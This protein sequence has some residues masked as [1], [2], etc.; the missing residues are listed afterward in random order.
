MI[1]SSPLQP[2]Y[3]QVDGSLQL[4]LTTWSGGDHDRFPHLLFDHN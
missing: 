3:G 1:R 4:G 2:L